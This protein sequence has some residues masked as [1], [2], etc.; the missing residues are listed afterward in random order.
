MFCIAIGLVL[1]HYRS[2]V[3]IGYYFD[4]TDVALEENQLDWRTDRRFGQ[5]GEYRLCHFIKKIFN[6]VRLQSIL[7]HRTRHWRVKTLKMATLLL[8]KRDDFP[9]R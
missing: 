9:Q 8:L 5:R 6:L 1:Y 3:M 7:S 4:R 2:R